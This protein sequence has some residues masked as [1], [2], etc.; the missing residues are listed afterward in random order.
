[1]LAKS[2][3]AAR[4]NKR[5]LVGMSLL[6]AFRACIADWSVVPSGSMNP[7]LVEGDTI[8]MNRLAY[9]VRVPATT[10]WLKRGAEPK[11]GDIVVFSSPEDGTKLVK[12]LIGLPG[13]VVEMRAEALY[14]NHQ[15][16]AYTP[17][18]DVAPGTLLQ[19]TAALPH[20]LW[21]EVLPGRSHPVMVLPEV[22][23][24]RSFGPI[25]VA[26]DHYLM[27]GDN[28]DNSRDSRYFGLVPRANLIARASHVAVSFDPDRWYLPRIARIGKPLD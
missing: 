6:F 2:L 11:R 18:P 28:R 13:D 25:T 4:D 12:R 16:V 24:R 17:L 19:A 14:I 5:F 20:D 3:K 9:G 21:A 23:A 1:L 7:T 10:V 8:L 22:P 27:L 15:R 26:A